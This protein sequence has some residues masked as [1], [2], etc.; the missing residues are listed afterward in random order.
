[1]TNDIISILNFANESY[2]NVKTGSGN[3][4]VL[5]INVPPYKIVNTYICIYLFIKF[6]E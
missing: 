5:I 3:L 4:P 6:L 2:F 1:M